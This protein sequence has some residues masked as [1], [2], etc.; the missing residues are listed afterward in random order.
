MQ[1]LSKAAS[2]YVGVRFRHMG[3]SGNTGLDCIG[4]IIKSAADI[5]ITFTDQAIYGRLPNEYGLYNKMQSQLKEKTT[6]VEDS[7]ILLFNI[8]GFPSHVGVVE[9]ISGELY[10]IHS[11]APM[12]KVVKHRLTNEWLDKVHTIFQTYNIK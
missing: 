7:D 12:K 6:N 9:N 3:R 1:T 4:L 11:Y 10:L 5:G 8:N 2:Q